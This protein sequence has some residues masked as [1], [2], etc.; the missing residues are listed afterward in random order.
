MS[1]PKHTSASRP[2]HTRDL[3]FAPPIVVSPPLLSC[4]SLTLH[5]MDPPISK[6]TFPLAIKDNQEC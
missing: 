2:W 3:L 1:N 4:W 5:F 6:D